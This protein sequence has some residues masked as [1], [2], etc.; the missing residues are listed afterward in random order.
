GL[1]IAAVVL[2]A[3]GGLLYWSDHHKPAETTT[4]SA[5]TPPKILTLNESDISKINL[6]K[7][8]ADE[9]ALAKNNSGKWQITSPKPL[10]TDSSAVSGVVA[11]LSSLSSDR[12]VEE[13]ASN[14]KPYGL[15]DPALEADITE[16]DNKS[17][18]LLIGDDTPTGNAVYAKLDGDPR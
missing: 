8:G 14:L 7:K 17:Q 2:A 13:K 9:L 6:K 15:S 1:I 10:E 4:A 16:K 18:K 12:V 3:L 5:D 11:T